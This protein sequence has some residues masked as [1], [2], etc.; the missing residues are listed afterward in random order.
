MGIFLS[1]V[2]RHWLV[3][4]RVVRRFDFGGWGE[5]KIMGK[6]MSGDAVVIVQSEPNRVLQT[7]QTGS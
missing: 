3:F 2:L 5:G 6:V 1:R 7:G 4:P